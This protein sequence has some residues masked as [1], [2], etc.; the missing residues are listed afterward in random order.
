MRFPYWS[1]KRFSTILIRCTRVPRYLASIEN[2]KI[3]TGR[4][5]QHIY[6]V[7]PTDATHDVTYS[8]RYFKSYL[9]DLQ[10]YETAVSGYLL[11]RVATY[12]D[13]LVGTVLNLETR[14]VHML[15]LPV[16]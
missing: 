13:L 16:L 11:S 5:Q 8:C 3:T 14:W 6:V 7:E 4:S 15:E 10:L 12:L 2:N 1:K 9:V